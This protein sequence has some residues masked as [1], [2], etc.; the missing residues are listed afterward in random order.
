MQCFIKKLGTA[1]STKVVYGHCNRVCHDGT[2]LVENGGHI[3]TV[4]EQVTEVRGG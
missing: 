4:A 2:L 3:G 1:V